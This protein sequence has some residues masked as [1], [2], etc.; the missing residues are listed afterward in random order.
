M[1]L[2]KLHKNNISTRN[3]NFLKFLNVNFSAQKTIL[4]KQFLKN[5]TFGK[6][7]ETRP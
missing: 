4:K 2:K 5:S 7:L 3:Q 1:I 6:P